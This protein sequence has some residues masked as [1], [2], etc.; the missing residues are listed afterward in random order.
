MS[1]IAERSGIIWTPEDP[2]DLLAVDV[3][4]EAS[5]SDFWGMVA[6]NTAG[7]NWLNGQLDTETYCDTLEHYGI[8]DPYAYLE[9]YSEH[10]DFIISHG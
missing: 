1:R 6:I 8:I 10:I 3:R 4:G 7:R 5:E 2:L 9:E